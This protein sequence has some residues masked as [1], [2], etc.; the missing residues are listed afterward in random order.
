MDT[1]LKAFGRPTSFEVI[2]FPASV[3]DASPNIYEI[4]SG[5]AEDEETTILDTVTRETREETGSTAK[6]IVDDFEG[7]EYL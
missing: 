7:F 4:L 3:E 6:W 5:H 1:K 2:V